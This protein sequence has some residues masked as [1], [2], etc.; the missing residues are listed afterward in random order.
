M[1]EAPVRSHR[2]ARVN[3]PPPLDVKK[4]IG[5]WKLFR[6]MWT[7]YCMVARLAGEEEDYKRALFLHTLGLVGTTY[8]NPTL[9]KINNNTLLALIGAR[10]APA[11][12]YTRGR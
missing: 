9:N 8:V 5:E 7:N 4:G 12:H 10:Q 11:S 6:Q 1:A 3:P 2:N